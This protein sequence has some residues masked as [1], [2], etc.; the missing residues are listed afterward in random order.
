MQI[1]VVCETTDLYLG[2]FESL[3]LFAWRN[4]AA[5]AMFKQ[6]GRGGTCRMAE[7]VNFSGAASHVLGAKLA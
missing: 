2:L 5:A 6:Y 3:T 1:M 4:Y 7:F